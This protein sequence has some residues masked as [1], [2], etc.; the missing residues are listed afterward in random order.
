MTDLKGKVVVITGA[1]DGLGK[2][3]SLRLAKEGAKLALVSKTKEKLEKSKAEVD[4]LGV[5]SEYF[6]CDIS[7][8]KQVEK[9]VSDIKSK[10]GT[11]DILV[12]NAGVWY[13]GSTE[14][15]SPEK[16]KELFGVNSMGPIFMARAVLPIMK[17]K[18]DGQI[19]NVASSAAKESASEWGVY[20]A[21]KWALRSFNDTLKGEL[22][23]TGIK[24]MGFYPGGM[25]T[26]M[27]DVSGFP[28]GVTPWMM[29]PQDVAEIIVFML[30]RPKDILMG[31]VDAVKF[32][33]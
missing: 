11:I 4:A 19:L 23:G 3:L 32:M 9:T 25:K 18:K 21:T 31:D 24:V 16:I 15:H 30:T 20:S 1:S 6:A 22:E 5:E 2:A 29:D 7:D 8:D 14:S 12:N 33:G 28:K 17:A 27:F 13:E 10:F 26:N